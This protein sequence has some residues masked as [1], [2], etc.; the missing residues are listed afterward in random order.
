M[1]MRR[2]GLLRRLSAIRLRI[3]PQP[4]L[5]LYQRAAQVAELMAEGNR[6][7]ARSSLH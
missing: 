1:A 5:A 3:L 2:G 6:G 4:D 7:A